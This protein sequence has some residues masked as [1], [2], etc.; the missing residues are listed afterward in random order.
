LADVKR[1]AVV[2]SGCG[3]RDGSEITEAVSALIAL[4]E[5]GATVECFAPDVNVPVA[6]YQN[7]TNQAALAGAPPRNARNESARISRSP[8][9]D[10]RDLREG[11]FDGLVFPGGMGAAKTLCDWA[12]KGARCHVRED[13][14][15]AILAFH[16]AAKPIG[17]ICIAPVL[18]ARALGPEGVTVTTGTDDET[19]REIE[20]TGARHA[21]CAVDDYVSDRD[22]KILSTP[23]YMHASARPHQVFAGIRKMV[24]ELVE[25]A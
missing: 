6:D 5:A 19:A 24:R 1:I 25:M 12:D 13:A 15:A 23:A 17:A 7:S 8:V 14:S 9:R 21:R 11:D 2:L 18:I 10:L 3:N 20:K 22:H 4:S 16:H